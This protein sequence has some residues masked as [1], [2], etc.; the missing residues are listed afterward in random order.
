V[1]DSF[2]PRRLVSRIRRNH[3][4]E[5]ATIHILAQRVRGLRVVGRSTPGGFILF[6]DLPTE[7]VEQAA[8]DALQRIKEGQWELAVHPTCGTNLVAGG[9]LAGIGAFVV[10]TPRRRSFW[11]WLGRLP[12]VLLAAVFGL[13]L[14]QRLGG[15]LQTHVTTDAHVGGLQVVA[16]T[17][18]ERGPLVIHHVRT[19]DR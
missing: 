13:I 7:V 16:V 5:H 2:L 17:R 10:L 18:E 1:F 12:L 4:L 6:G 15:F 9:L 8:R 3:A 11:E 14:G 19:E